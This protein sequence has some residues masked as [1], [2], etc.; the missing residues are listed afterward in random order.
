MIQDSSYIISLSL[1]KN[2]SNRGKP[3][4]SFLG[5]LPFPVILTDSDNLIRFCN[6]ELLAISP[7]S[8]GELLDS[9]IHKIFSLKD[10]QTSSE[11]LILFKSRRK[12]TFERKLIGRKNKPVD[13]LVTV[14]SFEIVDNLKLS[15]VFFQTFAERTYEPEISGLQAKLDSVQSFARLGYWEI[16]EE[17]SVF[18]GSEES[19]RLLG[20][21][22]L[23]EYLN[24][25][26]LLGLLHRK[27]DRENLERGLIAIAHTEYT[28]QTDIKIKRLHQEN[29]ETGIMKV[30]AKW[31]GN[32]PQGYFKG[33]IQDITETKKIEKELLRAKEK[34]ERADRLKSHFLT[35]LS[36]EIRTP[37]NAILG[38]AELLNLD[39]LTK[40]QKSDYAKIIRTKGNNLLSLIDDG[41]E[42]S[43]FETGIVAINKSE[44]A[45]YPLLKELF[46]EFDSRRIQLGKTNIGLELKVPEEYQHDRI[47]TDPGRLQ[48]MLSNLLS[49][50]IKFTEK[51]IVEFGYKKSG[52]FFKFYVKD[53]GIGIEEEDQDHIFNRFHEIEEIS[54]KKYGGSGLNLTIS[55]H[56]V[57]LLG[58]KIKVKSELNKGSRFQISIPIESPKRKKTD[59]TEFSDSQAVNWKDKVILIAED[60]DV[61]FRFLEA[62][63]QKSQTQILRAKTGKEAVELCKNIGKIDLVLMDIKMPEMNGFE[64]TK[65]IKKSRPDLPVIAQTAFAAQDELLRCQQSGCDDIITKPIDIKLLLR[66]LNDLL[67]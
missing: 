10:N 5:S 8:P 44:F 49:N 1:K 15:A 12:K 47:F 55:K 16:D 59:M 61:N 54:S 53:T 27:E 22:R 66:K 67:P 20:M 29:G 42:L 23:P 37:M 62:V 30:L 9:P 48:Q 60:E 64:A 50:A 26:D 25:D 35:N 63:L 41:I 51:G 11:I 17:R 45:L 34:A 43:K 6:H 65:I 36:H 46:D 3:Y 52:K 28:F 56:I 4:L 33:I 39:D 2:L 38:F 57:E 31:S 13:V 7:F 21:D 18:K 19:F 32:E 24:Y 14:S 58:G 40:E